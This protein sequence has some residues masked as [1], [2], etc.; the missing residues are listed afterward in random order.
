M[1][2]ELNSINFG[3]RIEVNKINAKIINTIVFPKV[4]KDV[5]FEFIV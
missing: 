1:S 5:L 4:D 3:I 2:G